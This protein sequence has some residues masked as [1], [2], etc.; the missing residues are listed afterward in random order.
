MQGFSRKKYVN[1]SIVYLQLGRSGTESCKY[2][3]AATMR[4]MME[5]CKG[6]RHFIFKN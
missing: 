6:P 5:K 3:E 1:T 2:K 4:Q